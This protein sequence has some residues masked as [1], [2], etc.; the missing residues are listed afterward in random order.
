RETLDGHTQAINCLR[1]S[2]DGTLLAS[3]GDDSQLRIW[4]LRSS[5][6][7]QVLRS[8]INGPVTDVAW[9]SNEH[10]L[11][12]LFSCT[13]GTIHIYQRLSEKGAEFTKINVFWVHR[14]AIE[15]IDVDPSRRRLA[16]VGGGSVKVWIIDSDNN[17][18]L[19]DAVPSQGN[20]ARSVHFS[21][22]GCNII[23]TFLDTHEVY[24]LY[25]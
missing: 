17:C 15:G 14:S 11:H 20:I 13:D 3:G 24:V 12:L 25:T 22:D 2:P 21:P 7:I 4:S 8:T 6:C 23:V 1:F 5:T 10:I 16:T 19:W 18:D 9:C